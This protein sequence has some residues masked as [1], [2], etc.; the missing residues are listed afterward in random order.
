MEQREQVDISD[1]KKARLLFKSLINS[2][3]KR[4]R[5]WI[6]AARVEEL[7]GKIQEARNILAQGVEHAPYSEDLWL[8]AARMEP[9]DRAKGILSKGVKFIPK[10][11]KLWLACA[12]K[13]DSTDTK[14]KILKKGLKTIPKSEKIW[15]ELIELSTDEEEAKEYLSNAVKCVPV[16]FFLKIKKKGYIGFLVGLRQIGTL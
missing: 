12:K 11:V 3:P 16:N 8:E 7:D 4:A 9:V 13:E 5:G 1:L 10:S 2:N 14:K 6:A 15:R